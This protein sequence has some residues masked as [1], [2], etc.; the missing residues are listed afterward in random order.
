LNEHSETYRVSPSSSWYTLI[1]STFLV[2]EIFFLI[3][4]GSDF[5]FEWTVTWL[6]LPILFAAFAI[7]H[8][9]LTWMESKS[10]CRFFYPLKKGAPP[11]V[12]RKWLTTDDSGVTFGDRHVVWSAIDDL[13]LTIFGTVIMRSYALCGKG[14]LPDI[15]LKFPFA[16]VPAAV[17]VEFLNRLKERQPA[18]AYNNRLT[19]RLSAKDIKGTQAVQSLGVVFMC[20][21]LLDVAQATF[22]FLEMNKEFYFAQTEARDGHLEKAKQHLEAGDSI[23][24]NGLPLS[25]V[26]S[27][28]LAEGT[29]AAGVY[30]S[31]SEALWRLGRKEEAL[32]DAKKAL[33][34][35]PVSHKLNL[36]VARLLAEMGKDR[37]AKEQIRA[38]ID[39]SSD[40]LMPRLYMI[41]VLMND[42]KPERALAMYNVYMDDLKDLV[43]GEEPLWPPGGNRFLHEMFYQDDAKFILDRL[44]KRQNAPTVSKNP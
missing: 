22:H 33:E 26:N 10:G 15:V 19:K 34:L 37:E 25:W 27:K 42:K 16:S 7:S 4:Y 11:I 17:Q 21:V 31:R 6:G 18:V 12:Y 13:Q 24:K 30:E 29:V 44:L 41:S 38:A 9:L 40:M 3:F 43:F 1:G 32:A 2:F 36:R 5:W 39:N 23:R 28:L 35:Y 14:A 8:L 20:V